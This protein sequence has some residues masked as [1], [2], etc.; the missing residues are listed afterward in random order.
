VAAA[1]AEPAV[2]EIPASG[3]VC[4]GT[5]AH[6]EAAVRRA[7]AVES[8]QADP[9]TRVVVA[10]FDEDVTSLESILDSLR[11]SGLETGE[12]KRIH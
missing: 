3:V 11:S 7:G 5:A 10:H 4:G 8:V 6:A 9:A 1:S 2:Y 12:P